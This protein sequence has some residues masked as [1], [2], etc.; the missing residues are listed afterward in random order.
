MSRARRRLVSVLLTCLVAVSAG[1]SGPRPAPPHSTP[2]A[3]SDGRCP[4]LGPLAELC[5]KVLTSTQ[6]K[7]GDSNWGDLPALQLTLS[8]APGDQTPYVS[9]KTGVNTTMTQVDVTS[10]QLKPR[11]KTAISTVG[12][13]KDGRAEAARELWVIDFTSSTM[14][15]ELSKDRRE[16]TLTHNQ[17]AITFATA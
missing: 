8:T 14:H 17:D 5:G 13:T 6:I 15:W 10:D 3:I 16:L 9:I 2:T 4:A 7:G 12:H 11:E 1:C